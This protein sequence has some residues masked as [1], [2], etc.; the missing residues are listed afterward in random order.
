MYSRT[1]F[2]AAKIRDSMIVS[3]GG[4][5]QISKIN[6]SVKNCQLVNDPNCLTFKNLK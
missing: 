2:Q 3:K 5:F 6:P 4:G 1:I